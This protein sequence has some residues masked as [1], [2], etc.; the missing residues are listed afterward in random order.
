MFTLSSSQKFY[1]Y[2]ASTD[3][4][5]SFDGLSGLILETHDKAPAN[6]SVFIFINKQR[7]KMK[8]LHWT[9]GGFVLYYKRLEEGSFELPQYDMDASLILLNYT[10]IVMLIDGISILNIKKRKRY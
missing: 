8:L 7:N 1:L 10:K 6:T 5:K 3:M 4:R 2:S 9:G